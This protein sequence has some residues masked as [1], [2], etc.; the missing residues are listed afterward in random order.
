MFSGSDQEER[1]LIGRCLKG[2]SCAWER[3][4]ELHYPKVAGIVRWPKWKFDLREVEDVTQESVEQ[5]VKSLRRFKFQ[6]ALATF[7]QKITMNVCVQQ[8]R[9]RTAAKR[10]APCLPLDPVGACERDID[11]HIPKNPYPNQEEMLLEQERLSLLKRG[12]ASLDQRCK[13]LVRLRFLEELS[14]QEIAIRLNAKQNTL[15]VQLK[16]CLLRIMRQF[17][18]DG[19]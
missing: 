9:K 2:D 15:V 3:L 6:S 11:A 1:I 8:I 5:I 19:F 18:T 10:Y 16:R 4:I 7:I 17:Q 13:D 12:L 14:F